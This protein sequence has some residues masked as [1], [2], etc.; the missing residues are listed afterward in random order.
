M[1]V[2]MVVVDNS[3]GEEG[4]GVVA[5]MQS[6]FPI[7]LHYECEPRRGISMARNRALDVAARRDAQYVAFV[8]D[9]EQVDADWLVNLLGYARSIGGNSIVHGEVIA[10]VPE[11]TPAPIAR[12]LQSR[13]IPTGTRLKVCATNNVLIPMRIVRQH[14]LRFDERYAL[15]GGE[16]TAFFLEAA[17]HAEIHQCREA[18]VHEA[19]CP[20]RAT[21]G[22]LSRRRYRCGL[23][24]VDFD[25]RARRPIGEP[26]RLV[27]RLVRCGLALAIARHEWALDLW[28]KACVSAGVCG[29]MLGLRYIEYRETHGS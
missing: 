6:T 19:I 13:S 28:L 16:D 7:P 1:A 21:L 10:V 12:R 26:Y 4:R 24:S 17:K 11:G 8:D 3:L 5:A 23:Q 22:W 14:G 9:D 29:G 25:P 27:T 15:T 2:V 18:V 20:S